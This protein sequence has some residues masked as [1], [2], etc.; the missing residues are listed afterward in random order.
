MFPLR[1]R[2]L[3]ALLSL[4][5]AVLS[6][7][8]TLHAQGTLIPVETATDF[9]FDFSGQ[10]LYISTSDGF[11]QRYNISTGQLEAPFNVGGRLNGID[12]ARDNSF[13]L[14]TQ[15]A[16]GVS[17]GTIHRVN[18][19]T[20]AV[21]NINYT[22][23][24]S[25]GGSYDVAI[26]SNGI[27]FVTT[28]FE[29][30]GW[31]PVRQ[32]NLAN[33]AISIRNDV[34]GSNG[35]QVTEA[36]VNRSSDGSRL[37]FLEG[38]ISSGPVF[39]YTATT[40][41]FG[42]S[43]DTDEFPRFAAV[44][45]NGTLVGTLLFSQGVSLDT[46][47]NFNYIHNFTAG[48][49]GIAF[50]AVTDTI[51]IV[52]T[53]ANQIIAYD[54]NTFAEKSR[55]NINKPLSFNGGQLVASPDGIHLA[56]ATPS[57]LELFDIRMA[58]P[59]LPPTFGTPRDMVF[60]HAG[61]RL[62]ITTAEGL[63][64]PYNLPTRTFGTPYNFGGSPFAIDITADDSIL[65]V[66]QGTSGLTQDAFQKV[67]LATG[68]M[69]NITYPRP[70]FFGGAALDVAIASNGL[71]LGSS[72]TIYQVNP[73]TNSISERSDSPG[74]SFDSKR[75]H[76]SADRRLLYFLENS[77]VFFYNSP[78][79]TFSSLIGTQSSPQSAAVNRNGT[80]VGDRIFGNGASLDSVP[81][82]N[83]IHNFNTLDSGIAFD[84][85][86]DTIY[87]VSRLRNQIIAYDTNTFAEKYR[88]DIGENVEGG[89]DFFGPGHMVA[90][91]DGHYLAL[92][93][94]TTLRV[95]G[96]PGAPLTNVV[97]RKTHGA[98][99]TF[100]IALPLDGNPG[101]ECRS[102][103]P[104][105][106]YTLVFT[107]AVNLTSVA[108]ASVSSLSFGNAALDSSMIN[109]SNAKQYI[110]NLTD[111]TDQQY[112]QVTLNNVNVAGA[113]TDAL[114]QIM[115]VLIGDTSGNRSVNSGDIGQTKSESGHTLTNANFREDVGVNGAISASD[116][117]LVKSKSGNSLFDLF[118]TLN[119][120]P[121]QPQEKSDHAAT[122]SAQR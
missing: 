96:L 73:V 15:N 63:V 113:H 114:S 81:D 55:L 34:P 67:T 10:R 66:A 107:F 85:L 103:G 109:P 120:H 77:S 46:A 86:Q 60:D 79:D 68:A 97:S 28:H 105:G 1:P 101:V 49:S 88:F 39:T 32:I 108:S 116:V 90:S 115:G 94:P 25:E 27:A 20:G 16:V 37:Y 100:D 117:L 80:L 2:Y 83:F 40:N 91:Q 22:R 71:A 99:G 51:Y 12:V 7:A 26:A 43:A 18:T 82:L 111:V 118:R 48:N 89:E 31:T 57:G 110:V 35:N 45:R 106:K 76:R 84:A 102:G 17:Q 3:T 54:T 92:N 65:L 56:L 69:L 70:Q 47:A 42:S 72:N 21:I 13:V 14:V 9:V 38:D 33:N 64:W 61:Q 74:S 44:N 53:D 104:S 121:Q 36:Q 87:G 19:S 75:L 30:S 50:D 122:A 24:F 95:F 4:T 29:G 11:V 23:E 98:A 41:S 93:T 59:A 58:T 112:V 5:L 62:Y 52:N 6:T 119:K 78:G 8:T